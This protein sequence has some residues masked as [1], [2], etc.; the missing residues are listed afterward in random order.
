MSCTV[1]GCALAIIGLLPFTGAIAAETE[2][3]GLSGFYVAATLGQ[4][5]QDVA[6]SANEIFVGIG[7][8]NPILIMAVRP[9]GIE[10]D[11]GQLSWNAAL[12][13]RIN[14]HFAA[15]LA[16]MRFGET[17]YA[18]HYTIP[19]QVFPFPPANPVEFTRS[20]STS[21]RG[22]ALSVLGLLPLGAGWDVFVRGGVLFADQEIELRSASNVG[23]TTFSDEVWIAGGGFNW[24]FAQRWS[25]RLEL[26]QTGKL[27]GT[28]FSGE[29]DLQQWSLSVLFRL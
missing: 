26:Q 6:L 28:M 24:S 21:V 14:A 16:Y 2:T 27:D 22:P 11:S 7:F 20:F 4:A 15:E 23:K 3:K 17:D 1:R 12:G 25:A 18:E 13:Y 8:P 5:E 19:S 29:S 10:V 9:D